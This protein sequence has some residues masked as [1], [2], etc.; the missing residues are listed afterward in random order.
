MYSIL[1]QLSKWL[2]RMFVQIRCLR[3]LSLGA[4]VETEVFIRDRHMWREVGG[5]RI[6]QR[7]KSKCS[8]AWRSR[9]QP[10]RE[11]WS[12]CCPSESPEPGWEGQAFIPQ[13]SSWSWARQL[14]ATEANAEGAESW[15]W[16]AVQTSWSWASSSSWKGALE[17]HPHAHQL[18]SVNTICSKTLLLESSFCFSLECLPFT[19]G[20]QLSFWAGKDPDFVVFKIYTIWGPLKKKEYKIRYNLLKLINKINKFLELQILSRLKTF[21]WDLIRQPRRNAFCWLL[22]P[23]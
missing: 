20:E 22:L 14:S 3:L 18:H 8:E 9:H 10:G 7:E 13:G 15:R 19:P 5:S 21:F 2:L 6:R 12:K 23:T 11:L 4:D 16:S 1:H 17:A